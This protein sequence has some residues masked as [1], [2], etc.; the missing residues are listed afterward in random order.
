MRAARHVCAWLCG[1]VLAL[2]GLTGLLTIGWQSDGRQLITIN[3]AGQPQ[4]QPGDAVQVKPVAWQALHTDDVIS[5]QD[6]GAAA[7]SLARRLIKADSAGRL[8][9]AAG[10][11]AV[12]R[13]V[14]ATALL[15]RVTAVVPYFGRV[16]A[17]Q[18]HPLIWLG[19]VYVPAAYLIGLEMQRILSQW[20]RP[21]RLLGY[22]RRAYNRCYEHGRTSTAKTKSFRAPT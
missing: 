10:P 21:Y 19:L 2:N 13:T 8:T 22:G 16:L 18:R 15:G 14:P 20:Q 7:Q 4:L 9:V 6:P 11:G 12:T 3:D 5:Y 17:L 1:L